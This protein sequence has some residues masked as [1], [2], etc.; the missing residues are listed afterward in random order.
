MEDTCIYHYDLKLKQERLKW[1]E[2]YCS[3]PNEERLTKKDYG[4]RFWVYK[5]DFID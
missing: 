5:W 2:A 1:T 3:A 4:I